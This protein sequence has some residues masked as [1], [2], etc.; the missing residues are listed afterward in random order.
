MLVTKGLK[1]QACLVLLENK[2]PKTVKFPCILRMACYHCCYI[3]ILL[4]LT[5]LLSIYLS[6]YRQSLTC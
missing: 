2:V 5:C 4:K 3:R 1:S 6:I